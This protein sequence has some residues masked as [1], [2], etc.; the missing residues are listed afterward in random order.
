MKAILFGASLSILLISPVL[1]RQAMISESLR[2]L[3]TYP[4]GEPNDVPILTR[5]T[6]LYPYHSFEGYSH[7][8]EPMEW[9]VVKREHECTEECVHAWAGGEVWG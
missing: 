8:S 4:F 6:R 2:S 9:Q 1:A 5:D 3:E 7:D